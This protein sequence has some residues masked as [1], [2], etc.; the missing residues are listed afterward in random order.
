MTAPLICQASLPVHPWMEERRK[1]LPGLAP[2][3]THDWLMQDDV[4]TAQMAYRDTLISTKPE[5]VYNCL[6]SGRDGAAELLST[7]RTELPSTNPAYRLEDDYMV[8]AD[9]G[10][11]NLSAD[12]PLRVAGQLVQEDFALLKKSGDA[13]ILVGGLICFPAHWT[14]S[15]KI[16]RSLF[17]LHAP[18]AAYDPSMGQRVERIFD[19]LRTEAPLERYNFLLYTNPDLH[20]PEPEASPKAMAPDA[21]IYVR[22]ERQTLRRLPE[23]QI[24]VFAIHTFLVPLA[25]LPKSA[26]N[27]LYTPNSE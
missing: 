15:E 20:Q 27:R 1:R 22:V 18:V 3:S 19:N 4:F 2:I 8:R 26:S 13:H 16:G 7:L 9:G 10:R 12:D 24:I 5:Q 11:I 14:L 21:P 25:T 23:T 6:P 17:K